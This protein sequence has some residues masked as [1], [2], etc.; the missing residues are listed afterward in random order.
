W[1][2]I[3]PTQ[4]KN[5]GR[6]GEE[7]ILVNLVSRQATLDTVP[8]FPVAFGGAGTYYGLTTDSMGSRKLLMVATP[9]RR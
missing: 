5:K 7:V 8:A 2:W 9:A 1:V 3:W 6:R 4:P